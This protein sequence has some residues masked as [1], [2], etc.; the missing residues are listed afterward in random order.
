MDAR[1]DML[2]RLR[3][4]REGFTLDR[5]FYVDPDYFRLD[6]EMIWYRDWLFVGH[7]CELDKPGAF[8]TV[9]IG[10]YPVVL[11]RD[12]KGTIRAFHNTCRHRGSRV[13]AAEQGLGRAARLPLSPVELRS[14]RA[15]PVRPPG[16]GRVRQVGL[17]AEAGRLRE[18]RRLSLRLPRRRRRRT[19]RRSAR[20]MEPYFAPHR[21]A[22][23]KVAHESTIIEKG[24][25]KLVWENNRECYHCSANH[26]ELCKTFPEAPTVTGVQSAGT[27]PRDARA[28]GAVRS[29]GAARALPHRPRRPVPRDA[30]A[31]P[32]R[33]RELHA[34]RH[35]GGAAGTSPTT[36]RPSASARCCS[37]TIRRPGTTC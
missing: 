34:E 25:W 28:L 29:G 3:S 6:L 14:R 33:R 9:Q 27:G 15:A 31:A 5:P 26:P 4:R 2:A 18:R 35:A 16:G 19:S 23:A 37:T 8:F 12:L 30:H 20:M 24:N 10:D 36:S 17:W 21:L 11:V 1:N 32:A 7:D 22:E 13:C